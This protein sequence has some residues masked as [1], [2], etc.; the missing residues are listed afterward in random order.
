[1]LK[2]L[3][4]FLKEKKG[5]TGVDITI[6]IGI[7]AIL[8]PVVL[9]VFTNIYLN[10]QSTKR[11]SEATS[12]AM[13]ILEAAEKLYYD[14]V[15]H[16]KLLEIRNSLNIPIGYEIKDEDITVT[17]YEIDSSKPDLVKT[18][19]VTIHFKVGKQM[20]MVK[21]SKI[22]AKEN[23]VTPNKPEISDGMIPVKYITTDEKT[24]EG[25]WQVTSKDDPVWYS[26]ENQKWA[27]IMTMDGIVLE[28]N[29]RDNR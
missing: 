3:S 15:T 24:G 20:D 17:S 12:Y 28:G 23:L 14:D 10:S 26:Y 1:M 9:L 8:T 18:I 13:Q 21:L 7:I 25:Y 27:N 22:K 19:E 4:K 29:T 5:I 2:I 6:A 11:N 16:D